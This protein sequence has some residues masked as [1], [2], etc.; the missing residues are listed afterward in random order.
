[1]IAIIL[2]VVTNKYFIG[3]SCLFVIFLLGKRLHY[4]NQEIKR[5]KGNYEVLIG[6]QDKQIGVLKL[7]NSE[8]KDLVVQ[9]RLLN[10]VLRDSLKLKLK[11]IISVTKASAETRIRFKTLLRDSVVV[12]HEN[13]YDT[14]RVY[15][16]LDWNDPWNKVKCVIENKDTN[17]EVSVS[18]SLVIVEH[19]YKKGKWFGSRLFSKRYTKI[20][21]V[22]SNPSASYHIE[23]RIEIE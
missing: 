5:Q 16:V 6:K 7:T 17:C 22:G 14:V 3:A 10:R 8:F 11:N 18:D 2:K 23:R 20:D 1:M 21:I 9:D 19:P 4:Q 15:Q 12:S 13:V